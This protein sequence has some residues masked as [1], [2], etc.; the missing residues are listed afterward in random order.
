MDMGVDEDGVERG[1]CDGAMRR[2]ST[3]R[4]KLTAQG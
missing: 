3:A 1:G 2:T 4:S